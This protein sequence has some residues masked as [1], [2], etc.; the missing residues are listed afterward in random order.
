MSENKNAAKRG[1][2]VAGTARKQLEKETGQKVVSDKNYLPKNN[3]KEIK[4]H[5]S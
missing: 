3:K 1:G 2:A 5:G 4:S